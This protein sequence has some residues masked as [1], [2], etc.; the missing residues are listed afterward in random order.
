M[1]NTIHQIRKTMHLILQFHILEKVHISSYNNMSNSD[2][3]TYNNSNIKHLV[4]TDLF[5]F[6]LI[7]KYTLIPYIPFNTI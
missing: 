1:F 5:N 3:I 6:I 7:S 2:N 4:N